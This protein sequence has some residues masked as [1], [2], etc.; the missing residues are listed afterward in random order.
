[1]VMRF[2]E[3]F[4]LWLHERAEERR[5]NYIGWLLFLA[6]IVIAQ[7]ASRSCRTRPSAV[8]LC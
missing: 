3:R 7:D 1:M 2:I 5:D 4:Q 6:F 8:R